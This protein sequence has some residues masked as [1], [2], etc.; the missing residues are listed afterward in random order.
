MNL[1]SLDTLAEQI[2]AGQPIRLLRMLNDYWPDV[3]CQGASFIACEF[4]Q[5]QFSD[6][7]LADAQFTDCRFRSCRFSHA[8]F[9]AARF[10]K[11]RL[12]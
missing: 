9:S 11:L 3:D 10:Q 1:V 4:E 7:R 2:N 5:V 12:S 8:D 6:P